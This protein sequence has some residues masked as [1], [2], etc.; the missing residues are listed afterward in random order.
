MQNPPP[1]TKRLIILLLPTH[2]NGKLMFILCRKCEETE[3]SPPY[4]IPMF[5]PSTGHGRR[6]IACALREY[7]YEN[8]DGCD[9]ATGYS[10][11]CVTLEEKR[12][13]I[14]VGNVI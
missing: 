8:K 11:D 12:V 10:T 7:I 14:Q 9:H 5:H 4:T 1:S 13:Y 6:G 2:I 3:N